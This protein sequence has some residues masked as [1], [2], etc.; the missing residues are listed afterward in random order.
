MFTPGGSVENSVPFVSKTATSSVSESF[1]PT[2]TPPGGVVI[3]KLSGLLPPSITTNMVTPSSQVTWSN[4]VSIISAKGA[5]AILKL[6]IL[7]SQLSGAF[8]SI[9]IFDVILTS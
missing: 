1:A 2:A 8:A 5:G 3:K 9:A 7:C 4:C 6:K